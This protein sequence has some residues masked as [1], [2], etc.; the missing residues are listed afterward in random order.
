[1]NDSI[2]N[3]LCKEID[4]MIRKERPIRE[5]VTREYDATLTYVLYPHWVYPDPAKAREALRFLDIETEVHRR[6]KMWV[7]E[8]VR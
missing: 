2:E 1:M 3:Q 5:Q 4:F 6:L 7:E 8:R